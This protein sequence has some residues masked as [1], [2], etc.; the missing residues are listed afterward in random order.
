[1][2]RLS[3][4]MAIFLSFIMMFSLTACNNEDLTSELDTAY[5]KI[6]ELNE[7]IDELNQNIKDIS[8][9]LGDNSTKYTVKFI[10]SGTVIS[11]MKTNLISYS[12]TSIKDNFVLEGWFFD[13]YAT[14]PVSFPL[15]VNCDMTLYAK[16]KETRE[17]L[18]DRFDKYVSSLE[19]EKLVIDYP[20]MDS[21]YITTIGENV[22]L[23][24]EDENIT[25]SYNYTTTEKLFIS[26]SFKYGCLDEADGLINYSMSKQGTGIYDYYSEERSIDAV[27]KVGNFYKLDSRIVGQYNGY[28]DFDTNEVDSKIL[29]YFDY[30]LSDLVLGLFNSGYEDTILFY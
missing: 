27:S 2:K 17:S 19:D 4:L 28:E 5:Q 21:V 10:T 24:A 9:S 1:M 14:R 30:S 6:D 3:I 15:S 12:P 11:D 23:T 13:A 25:E 16:F 26:L 8:E 22:Y 29:K 7:K 20:I 18:A